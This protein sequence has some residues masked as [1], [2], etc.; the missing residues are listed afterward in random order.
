MTTGE[1]FADDLG[2]E[3]E[4]CRAAGTAEVG[5]VTLQIRIRWAVG[6]SCWCLDRTVAVVGSGGVSARF[7]TAERNRGKEV[8]RED[9]GW[10][11]STEEGHVR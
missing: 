3:A 10:G 9:Q 5:L 7:A 1:T 4:V 11:G 8:G 2:S 6:R